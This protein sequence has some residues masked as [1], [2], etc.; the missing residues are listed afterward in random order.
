MQAESRKIIPRQQKI[1]GKRYLR[2]KASIFPLLA[3]LK[4]KLD[5]KS[6]KDEL[7][8]THE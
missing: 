8:L 5:K 6:I 1:F 7:I 4:L 2:I 3:F